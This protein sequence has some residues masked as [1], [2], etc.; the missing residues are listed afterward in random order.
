MA[1]FQKIRD[2]SLLSL[3]L[4]G[5]SLLLFI[6]TDFFQS[7]GPTNDNT[8]DHAGSFEGKQISGQEF[9]NYFATIAYLTGIQKSVASLTDQEK[10]N[11][12]AQ[13]W[14]QLMRE[15]VLE[16]EA[17]KNGIK[18]TESEI[19]DM[20]GG[21]HPFPF[22]VG[23]IF[24]G[25]QNYMQIQSKL[26]DDVDNYTQYASVSPNEAEIIKKFGVSLRIQGKVTA[27]LQNAFYTTKIESKNLYVQKYTKKDVEIAAIPYYLIPDSVVEVKD[28]EIKAYYEKNKG[29][30]KINNATKKV[31]YGAYRVDPTPADDN[32]IREWAVET[33]KLFK[34]EDN[35]ALFVK[36]ESEK[37]YD[38][39]YYK[40]GGGLL[41]ELDDSLFNQPKG[42]VY[43]PYQGFENGNKTYNVAKIIDIKDMADSALVSQ[44]LISPNK[45]LEKLNQNSPQEEVLAAF[46]KYDAYADSVFSEI[47]NRN[48]E[49]VAKVASDDTATAKNGGDLGWIQEG[50]QAYPPQ[51]LDSIFLSDESKSI[52]KVK[53]FLN[54]G[55]YYYSLIKVRSFGPK[56]KKLKVGII[57]KSVLPGEKTRNNYFNKINQVAI[58]LNE[59]KS[60]TELK[61]SFE[62]YIDSLNVEPAQY[63]VNDLQNARELVLWAFNEAEEG[64]SKVFDFDRRYIVALA[65]EGQAKGYQGWDDAEVKGAITSKLLKEKKAQYVAEKLGTVNGNNFAQVTQTFP[66]AV[67]KAYQAVDL[68]K[69]VADYTYEGKL[70]GAIAALKEGDISS[71]VAGNDATYYV[72]AIKSTEAQLD[73][74]TNFDLEKGQLDQGVPN[75][76][77]LAVQELISEKAD[78]EDNRQNIR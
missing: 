52:K 16:A 46:S 28:A 78:I 76:V 15:N 43:G 68:E 30:Y 9:D 19:E 72:R 7:G 12:S 50:S 21:D 5:G 60:L 58:Q 41:K 4:I 66:G 77:E 61:D 44:I 51:F 64:Q 8:E 34:E 20:I 59:G 71:A 1:V 53:V 17:E 69:G 2:N 27:L 70:T 13:A 33:V 62:I 49:E 75:R 40:K 57:T 31:I 3:V 11:I 56:S 63:V 73:E 29:K 32:E 10:Q 14:N 39:N 54:N 23:R 47:N 35:D 24:G 25:Q 18:V 42:Y 55:I 48:F 67:V 26:R 37:P 38:D 22:Y 65:S 74:N 6:L 45:F 36:T